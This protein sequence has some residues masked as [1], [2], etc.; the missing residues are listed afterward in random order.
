M[1][2][3]KTGACERFASSKSSIVLYDPKLSATRP[4]FERL[5][6]RKDQLVLKLSNIS[7]NQDPSLTMQLRVLLPALFCGAAYIL[8]RVFLLVEDAIAFRGQD[9]NIY[10]TLNW[11]EFL[12]HI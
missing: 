3:M 10:K 6:R 1:E 12:P 7:P 2:G 5:K 9:P 8:A 4:F 11:V